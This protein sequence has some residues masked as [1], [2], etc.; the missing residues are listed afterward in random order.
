[1]G[2]D[3]PVGEAGSI[4][5][6]IQSAQQH[7]TKADQRIATAI[8]ADYPMAGLK[9][10]VDLGKDTGCSPATVLRFVGKLGFSGYPEFQKM[11]R[12]EL[13]STLDSP[14][15][16]Y[17]SGG[18]LGE[19]GQPLAQYAGYATKL[20]EETASMVPPQEFETIVSLLADV[21][22]PVYITGGRYS[23]GLAQLFGYGLSSVRGRVT[24][25][26][27]DNRN[28]VEVL[29]DIGKRDVVF[30]FDFRRYQLNIRRFAQEAAA[31]GASLVLFTD[32]WRSPCARHA[33]H[34]L[35]LPV[36][37]PSVFDSG[38]SALL[39]LEALIASLAERLD[40]TGERRIARIEA[41]YGRIIGHTN[42]ADI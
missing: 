13:Q 30:V 8:L 3:H 5:E 21:R 33:N 36:A 14:L 39:C 31:T 16:R 27:D 26:E 9:T 40:K 18:A 34:V 42:G 20:M 29:A 12:D 24:L 38:L 23:R 17:K 10:L 22:R 35:A 37:S 1:M 32:R 19:S 41:L 28:I 4:R 7:L 11:L 25:V 6:R 15:S 2:D